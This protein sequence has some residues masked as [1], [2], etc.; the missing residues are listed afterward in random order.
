MLYIDIGLN[1]EKIEN[2]E[3]QGATNVFISLLKFYVFYFIP[4]FGYKKFKGFNKNFPIQNLKSEILISKS[5]SRVS[6]L[7]QNKNKRD[8][9]LQWPKAPNAKCQTV[10]EFIRDLRF[11]IREMK[12]MWGNSWKILILGKCKKRECHH[13]TD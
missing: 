5:Q 8:S 1:I 7:K 6:Q 3:I 4:F 12:K 2:S 10:S 11:K 9:K 13:H